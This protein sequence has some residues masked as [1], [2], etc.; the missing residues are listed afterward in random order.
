MKFNPNTFIFLLIVLMFSCKEEH[1]N[2]ETKDIKPDKVVLISVNAPSKYVH[3]LKQ[4]SVGK[5]LKDSLG[6]KA[7]Y[8]KNGFTY[9]DYMNNEQTWLPKPNIPDTIVIECYTE[10]LEL[11]THNFFTSIKETFLV[12]NGDTVVFNYNHN[13]PKAA[14]TNR[15]V[16]GVE[17]NYNNYRLKKLFENKYTSHYLIFGNLF[18]NNDI[19]NYEQN[20]IDYY[21]KANNDYTKE[22]QLLDSLYNSN[23]ITEVNYNYRIDALKMLMERH[24]KLKNIEKWLE[25]NRALN[26]KEAIE[27]NFGFD[28]SKTDS[29]MKFSFFRNYLNNIS[30][31]NLGY[32]EENNNGNSGGSYIDSRIRFDSILK[33]KRFNQ[34]AKNY[35]LFDAYKGIVQNFRVKDKEKYFIKLQENTTNRERLNRLEKYYKLDFD[36][37]DKL[38]LTNLKNDTTAFSNVLK[39]NKGKWLYIDFWASWCI[40]CR[41]AMPESNKLKKEFKNENIEFIYMSL[42]DKKENWKK[43]IEY[44]GILKSQNYFIENGNVSKVIEDLGIKTIPHYLIYNPNGDLINGFANRPGRGAKEQLIKLMNEH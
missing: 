3:I 41:K 44:D 40:P 23:I 9:L 20:S 29:L 42:N 12:K 37:S 33:D 27:Q 8:D 11:S 19:K 30:K 5:K 2:I 14:I 35:L 32:I 1:K 7:S 28:L 38:I 10:Y 4:D 24:K 36:K 31:Y 18:L 25:Q 43:A 6:P 39:N 16:N 13:I 15:K 17:L 22:V 26:N 34:T 21:N